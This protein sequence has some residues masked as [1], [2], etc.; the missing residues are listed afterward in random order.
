MSKKVKQFKMPNGEIVEIKEQDI[1]PVPEPTP[2]PRHSLKTSFRFYVDTVNGNDD[3]DGLTRVTAFKT[4]NRFIEECNTSKVDIRCYLIS[5]GVYT[6]DEISI[7]GIALHITA[8]SDGITLEFTN[9]T[10]FYNCHV[11]IQGVDES[12]KMTL[13]GAWYVDGG[14]VLINYCD[15][16]NY[17]RFYNGGVQFNYCTIRRA[18]C[19]FSFM[20]MHACTFTP[21][22]E[23]DD[24]GNYYPILAYYNGYGYIYGASNIVLTSNYNGYFIDSAGGSINVACAFV[25]NTPYKFSTVLHLIA[26][27]FVINR[28][29]TV[30]LLD[31][32]NKYVD[33]DNSGSLVLNNI[34]NYSTETKTGNFTQAL[35]DN[36]ENYNCLRMRVRPYAGGAFQEVT[37]LNNYSATPGYATVYL[38]D[39]HA[40]VHFDNNSVTIDNNAEDNSGL[41]F[42]LIYGCNI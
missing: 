27:T 7:T 28:V 35:N 9:N 38:G 39:S 17:V 37:I 36:V 22:Y 40:R 29:R 13:R 14:A 33:T 20:R 24:Q 26:S 6:I 25:N 5:A 15:V 42:G 1:P 12:H 16:Y 18:G 19:Y 23:Q 8:L 21:S 3:N 41:G 34:L 11:N 10:A 2:V 32:G 31:F 4:M 30:A